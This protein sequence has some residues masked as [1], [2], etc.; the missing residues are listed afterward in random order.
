V[1]RRT[2]DEAQETR[3][4]I[5]DAAEHLFSE[6]GVS[7][8]SL[9]DIAQAALYLASPRS[10]FVTGTALVVDGGFMA[11]GAWA[12]SAGASAKS[13]LE[14]MRPSKSGREND[15]IRVPSGSIVEGVRTI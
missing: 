7:R 4:R 3:N 11:Q 14:T 9:E 6:H 15:G 12:S 1:V 8:T 10:S 2:K 13:S 5:L